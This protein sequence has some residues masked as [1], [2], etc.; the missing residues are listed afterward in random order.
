MGR[1]AIPKITITMNSFDKM[2]DAEDFYLAL[3][4]AINKGKEISFVMGTQG[5]II[6]VDG[7][8]VFF[9]ADRFVEWGINL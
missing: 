2:K 4:N 3:Q 6:K 8:A 5:I 7:E 1:H 9:N